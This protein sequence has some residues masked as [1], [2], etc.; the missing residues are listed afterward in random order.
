MQLKLYTRKEVQSG[1]ISY[2]EEEKGYMCDVGSFNWYLMAGTVVVTIAAICMS[3]KVLYYLL[4]AKS[5]RPDVKRAVFF[6]LGFVAFFVNVG[7]VGIVMYIVY[8]YMNDIHQLI[9]KELID[10]EIRKRFVT[11]STML[12]HGIVKVL[13]LAVSIVV[14]GLGGF[15][16][17][18]CCSDDIKQPQLHV[19]T[20]KSSSSSAAKNICSYASK[21]AYFLYFA[22]FFYF[23]YIW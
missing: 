12:S 3:C 16:T 19:C 15:I 22:N 23:A 21:C 13:E 14:F 20:P 4:N 17:S 18:C 2:K 1:E 7:D 8:I 5:E 9:V 6:S 11:D 10:P